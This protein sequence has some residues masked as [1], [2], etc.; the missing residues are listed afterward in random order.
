M[1]AQIEVG[2]DIGGTKVL[3]IAQGKDV[4]ERWQVVIGSQ[5]SGTDAEAAIA[6]FMQTLP[7]PPMALGIAIPGLVNP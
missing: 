4:Q 1:T 7:T 6:Q 3:L 5:F 2:I